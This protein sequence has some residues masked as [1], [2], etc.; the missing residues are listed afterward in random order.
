MVSDN[1]GV[2][3]HPN[4]FAQ[5]AKF[6]IHDIARFYSYHYHRPYGELEFMNDNLFIAVPELAYLI[7]TDYG[8]GP[9]PLIS[10]H[11]VSA[12]GEQE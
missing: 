10:S 6:Q 4:D 11:L 2:P 9:P 3:N 7:E 1:L 12:D 8:D 5:R